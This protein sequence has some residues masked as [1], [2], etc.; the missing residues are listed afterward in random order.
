M[1]VCSVACARVC[2]VVRV[3]Q[4]F[5]VRMGVSWGSAASLNT[6]MVLIGFPRSSC[7]AE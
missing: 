5:F 6:A 2:A 4:Y 7:C 1:K 3:V